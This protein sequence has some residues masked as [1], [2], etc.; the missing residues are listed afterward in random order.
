[1]ASE[2]LSGPW[3][4]IRIAALTQ[5]FIRV[6]SGQMSIDVLASDMHASVSFL[7]P[8]WDALEN[9]F[10]DFADCGAAREHLVKIY[11]DSYSFPH[12]KALHAAMEKSGISLDAWDDASPDGLSTSV[13]MLVEAG[14]WGEA[15]ILMEKRCTT[16]ISESHRLH[17]YFE[18]DTEVVDEW[19]I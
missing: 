3:T 10:T 8:M 4:P 15:K 11:V 18:K 13:Q 6:L 1:M 5:T 9:E 16:R 19:G 17:R 7:R 14:F 12:K 2:P